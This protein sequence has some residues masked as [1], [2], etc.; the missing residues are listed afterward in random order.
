MTSKHSLGAT[1]ASDKEGKPSHAQAG[2][3]WLRKY[4]EEK[5]KTEADLAKRLWDADWTAVAEVLD[6]WLT[7]KRKTNFE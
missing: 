1:E 6:P 2:E 7:V 4:L 3:K 5:G